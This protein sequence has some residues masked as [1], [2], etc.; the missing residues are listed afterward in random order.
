M[1]G[2]SSFESQILQNLNVMLSIRTLYE[3]DIIYK[4]EAYVSA[5]GLRKLE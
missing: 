2:L 1:Y 4:Y 3:L 5:A